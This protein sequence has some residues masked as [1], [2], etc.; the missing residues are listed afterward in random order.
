MASACLGHREALREQFDRAQPVGLVIGIARD[1][2]LVRAERL[3]RLRDCEAE[4][5]DG[6]FVDLSKNGSKRFCSVR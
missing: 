1:H 4:D 5:C 2:H 3:D 6:V